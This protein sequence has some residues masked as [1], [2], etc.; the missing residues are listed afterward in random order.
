M[1]NANKSSAHMPTKALD[2][3]RVQLDIEIYGVGMI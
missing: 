3:K 1:P 2:E